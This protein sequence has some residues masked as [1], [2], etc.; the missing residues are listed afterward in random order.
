M[1]LC[2]KEYYIHR[3]VAEIAIGRKLEKG[4]VVHHI[5]R[6]RLNNSLDNLSIISRSDH[7]LTHCPERKNIGKRTG[8]RKNPYMDTEVDTRK[9]KVC[10]QGFGSAHKILKGFCRKHYLQ[11][12]KG[13]INVDGK[14][15]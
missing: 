3:V 8:T 13:K 4:E 2:G 10:G 11:F 15:I 1:R 14:V 12:K 9:C 6:N 5:D 7:A